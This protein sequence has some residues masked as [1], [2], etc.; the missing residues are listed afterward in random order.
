VSGAAGWLP[1]VFLW[2]PDSKLLH[3]EGAQ[4]EWCGPVSWL[5]CPCRVEGC[6]EW[7]LLVVWASVTPRVVSILCAL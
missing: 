6:W 1:F 5:L 3:V 2:V 4:M 7:R